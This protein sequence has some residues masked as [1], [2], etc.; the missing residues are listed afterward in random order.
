MLLF[1]SISLELNAQRNPRHGNRGRHH[2]KVVVVKRSPFR[3]ARVS[4]YYPRWRPTHAYSRRWIYFPKYNLYW[5]NW[6][7]HYVFW[8]G[9]AWLSQAA[10]PAVIVNVTLENEKS[11]ELK[12]EEDDEDDIY[13]ANS[14]H[15]SSYKPE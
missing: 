12:E 9:K 7:E 13:R 10:V 11:T 2:K 8:N 6:R 4:V 15:K 5:D 1:L 3:P 14:D